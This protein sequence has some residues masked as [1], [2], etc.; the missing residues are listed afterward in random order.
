MPTRRKLHE[1]FLLFYGIRPALIS[2][3]PAMPTRRG[4]AIETSGHLIRKSFKHL[5][6]SPP[7]SD[8]PN[9]VRQCK[10]SENSSRKPSLS[11]SRDLRG[12]A[13]SGIFAR[14]HKV[15]IRPSG[16]LCEQQLFHHFAKP[17]ECPRLFFHGPCR[18]A[19]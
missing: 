6:S 11:G 3:R 5:S 12:K 16:E 13:Y 18:C 7:G 9:P 8:F 10:N 4:A 14:A 17:I 2:S 1:H 19:I 15:P